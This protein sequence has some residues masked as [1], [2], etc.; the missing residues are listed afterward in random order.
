MPRWVYEQVFYHRLTSFAT[1]VEQ[2]ERLSQ[3][4]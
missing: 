3:V 4:A 1:V 2:T